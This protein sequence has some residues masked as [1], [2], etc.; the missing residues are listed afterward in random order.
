MDKLI[1]MLKQWHFSENEHPIKI[2]KWFR[3]TLFEFI[4]KQIKDYQNSNYW[5]KQ[6][7]K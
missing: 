6:L 4:T 2:N 1:K 7:K 5:S 3:K